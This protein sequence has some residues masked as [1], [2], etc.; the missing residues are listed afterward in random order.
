MK[1]KFGVCFVIL[2]T[3]CLSLSYAQQEDEIQKIFKKAVDDY[4]AGKPDLSIEGL[5]RVVDLGLTPEMAYQLREEAGYQV[6]MEMLT[7]GG[8][9]R[10]AARAFLSVSEQETADRETNPDKIQEIVEK[11][12][13]G[14]EGQWK[15][16]IELSRIGESAVQYMIPYLKSNDTAASN[17]RTALTKMSGGAVLPLSAAL[18]SGNRNIQKNVSAVLGEIG[19]RRGIADLKWMSEK[20]SGGAGSIASSSLSKIYSPV[21]VE[22]SKVEYVRRAYEYYISSPSYIKRPGS[23]WFVWTWKG[24]KLVGTEVPSYL[25][26]YK[27]AEQSCYNALKSDP[28]YTEAWSLLVRIYFAQY[29]EAGSV[30]RTARLNQL[31]PEQI[32]IFE[33][34]RQDLEGNRVL[35]M[36]AGIN[37]MMLALDQSIEDGDGE[38]GAMCLEALAGVC[39]DENL[40]SNNPI[41]K[42]LTS[43]DKRLKYAAAMALVKINPSQSFPNSDQV[44]PVL[45]DALGESDART[46]LVVDNDVDVRNR[47]LGSLNK[48]NYAAFGA[49]SG[50]EALER[51]KSFPT[52]DLII[53]DSSLGTGNYSLDYVYNNLK[54]DFRTRR[55]PIIITSNAKN[56]KRD[57]KAYAEKATIIDKNIAIP[58]LLSILSETLNTEEKEDYRTEAR[59]ISQKAA[60]ALASIE[61]NRGVFNLQSAAGGLSGVLTSRPDEIRAPAIVAIGNIGDPSAILE[62]INVFRD[63]YANAVVR[64]AAAWSLGEILRKTGNV[65]R[66]AYEA[67]REGLSDWNDD[68]KV[69]SG[70]AIGKASLPGSDRYIVFKEERYKAD[71]P[72]PVIDTTPKEPG[73]GAGDDDDDD[74]EDGEGDDDDDDEFGGFDD[75]DDDDDDEDDEE[76]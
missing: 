35:A 69:A 15:A 3:L 75:D 12:A 57:Q 7:D 5:K 76:F 68:V 47:F 44:I 54:T 45:V 29:N 13:G 23:K 38:V 55:I 11:V 25:Y 8:D 43:S 32:E 34:I 70:K 41:F 50:L 27:I 42:A 51:A 39:T 14:G 46:I 4:Q 31:S 22:S 16:L 52:E 72:Q 63:P 30:V 1:L 26:N 71:R 65:D 67:L 62:L 6:F 20:N 17:I 40:S 59:L 10:E 21:A 64:A 56:W 53:L 48:F 18:R 37:N 74:G 9:M 61:P 28:N 33:K 24:G 60:E 73:S 49:S 58:S 19:D 66:N 36:A 2:I